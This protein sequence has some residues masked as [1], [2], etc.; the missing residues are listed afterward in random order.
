MSRKKGCLYFEQTH[1]PL[2]GSDDARFED[3]ATA[4]ST[5][6]GRLSARRPRPSAMTPTGWRSWLRGPKPSARSTDRAILG[7]F[8]GNF[9]E[10]GQFLFRNDNFFALLAGDHPRARTASSTSSLRCIWTT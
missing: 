10:I 7:L 4:W 6:T 5:L 9:L 3:L 1:F 8:G 2:M